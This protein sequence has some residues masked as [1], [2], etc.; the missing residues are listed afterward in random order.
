MRIILHGNQTFRGIHGKQ[1]EHRCDDAASGP[2]QEQLP[3]AFG[4]GD[5]GPAYSNND[6]ATAP[7]RPRSVPNLWISN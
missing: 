3:F 2:R 7:N 1:W 6:K 5:Q 4:P